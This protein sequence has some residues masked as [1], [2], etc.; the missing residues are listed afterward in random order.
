MANT[1]EYQERP[2]ARL[3][4][5]GKQLLKQVREDLNTDPDSQDQ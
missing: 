2:P 5:T 3:R 1:G 4:W